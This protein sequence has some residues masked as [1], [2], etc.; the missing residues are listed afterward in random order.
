[1][2]T[3]INNST[4]NIYI[5]VAGFT[6]R[7]HFHPSEIVHLK[8]NFKDEINQNF[9]FFIIKP[10]KSI[11]FDFSVHFYGYRGIEV[12]SKNNEKKYFLNFYNEIEKRK[13]VSY[14]HISRFQLEILLKK[15][16][17]YLLYQDNGFIFHASA[18]N[19]NGQAVLFTGRSGAGKSTAM[20]LLREKFPALAD[21]NAVIRKENNKFYFYQ[22]PL[23][24]KIS[25]EAK[26]SKRYPLG[27]I[28]FLKKD[29]SFKFERITEKNYILRRLLKQFWTE[30]NFT[31]RHLKTLMELVAN[32]D[33]FYYLFFAKKKEEINR[34]F[35][36]IK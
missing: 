17:S 10:E 13:I 21:D 19:I 7:F 1:L 36:M 6:I 33:E 5:S 30:K 28:F 32:F 26:S 4:D 16:L 22:I 35:R 8:D 25:I 11:K 14:Y 9:S 18:N 15:I 20:S 2:R 3:I 23:P 34:L 27:K 29:V 24:E 31:E 12:I